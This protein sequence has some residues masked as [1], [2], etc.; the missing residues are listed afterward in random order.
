[1]AIQYTIRN[2]PPEV[3]RALKRKAKLT[4]KSLNQVVVDELSTSVAKAR[5]ATSFDW[6]FG[7]MGPDAEFDKAIADLSKVDKDFWD[8]PAHTGH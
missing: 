2:I 4:R 8:D 6:L 1:M 7:S 5:E 3:D